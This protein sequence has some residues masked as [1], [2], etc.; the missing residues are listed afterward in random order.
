MIRFPGLTTDEIDLCHVLVDVLT[1]DAERGVHDAGP[2]GVLQSVGIEDMLADDA[3]PDER[4]RRLFLC[5]YATGRAG[6]PTPLASV[7][8]A[9]VLLGVVQQDADLATIVGGLD[10]TDLTCIEDGE[11]LRV[12][13]TL[14]V[15]G[16]DSVQR[17]LVPTRPAESDRAT[18]LVV[19][20]R[21]GHVRPRIERRESRTLLET[22]KFS[23]AEAHVVGVVDSRDIAAAGAAAGVVLLGESVGIHERWLERTAEHLKTRVQFGAPLAAR[24][25]TRHALVDW[26]VVSEQL[27][28]VSW[29]AARSAADPVYVAT[30]RLMGARAAH[31]AAETAIQLHGGVGM[32]DELSLGR[33][34]RRLLECTTL[35]S[36]TRA[37][38][39][40]FLRSTASRPRLTILTADKELK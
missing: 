9:N 19:D 40:C 10:S 22:V 32:V 35:V 29:R 5:G 24:Q 4:S 25:A 36:S 37:S 1:K 38:R 28:A 17:L 3:L 14:Q 18:L 6:S 2:W 12:S 11:G 31:I 27:R 39:E 7:V 33:S 34:V 20:L 30:A 21:D 26:W 13:G 15:E 8:A 23:G 16:T